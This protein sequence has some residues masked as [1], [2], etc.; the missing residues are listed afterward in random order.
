MNPLRRLVR[1]LL[2]GELAGLAKSVAVLERKVGHLVTQGKEQERLLTLLA[3]RSTEFAEHAAA[4]RQMTRRA[5]ALAASR[6]PIIV[7]PWC[8]EVGFEL[9]Y[10]I[11]FLTWLAGRRD[12]DR[13]R[14]IVLTRGGARVWYRHLA[15]EGAEILDYVTADTFR[16][17]TGTLK[18]SAV[19]AFDRDLLRKVVRARRLVRPRILH[20]Q[21]MYRLFVPYWKEL[22]VLE[23]ITSFLTYR[24]LE[25][26]ADHPV[27]ESL[28][29]EYVAV[30]FY[31]SRA[32]PDT[33]ENRAFV[34]RVV[35]AVS[36]EHPVVVLHTGGRLDD[37]DD[38]VIPRSPRVHVV[39][40]E[41]RDNLVA[42][43]A[44][45]AKA[46]AFV[47][48]YGG[49]SYLAPLCGVDALSF[50]SARDQFMPFHLEHAQ[51]TFGR[52]GHG[53]FVALDVDDTALVASSV[54]ALAARP[55]RAVGP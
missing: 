30:K 2:A 33:P 52:P 51:R 45:L 16:E 48:T 3:A 34:R 27:L 54:A 38:A 25:G 31:F 55:V 20:P 46:A 53:R 36:E 5:T 8:G 7:G 14:L 12:L 35:D 13:R 24:R 9:L 44:V 39:Q 42:Q 26:V 49:F 18:Q 17:Q 1:R 10:W 28:P 40:P 6:R 21:V 50:Y 43:T 11:P 4:H 47:G 37:H 22:P 23:P 32:F 15:D 29:D 41:A 19:S